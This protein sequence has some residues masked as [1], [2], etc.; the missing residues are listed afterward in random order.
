[1]PHAF[2]FL[3]KRNQIGVA[4]V[5]LQDHVDR[6]FNL[7]SVGAVQHNPSGG[8]QRL[9]R[10]GSVFQLSQQFGQIWGRLRFDYFAWRKVLGKP[11]PSPIPNSP[12][13]AIVADRRADLHAQASEGEGGRID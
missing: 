8:L 11:C 1:M 7:R 6:F 9:G 13:N 12:V 3:A 4:G 5:L 2:Q 10:T